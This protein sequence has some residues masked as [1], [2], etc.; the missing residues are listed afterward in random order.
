MPKKKVVES[1]ETAVRDEV[2]KAAVSAALAGR[3]PADDV[4]DDNSSSAKMLAAEKESGGDR[5]KMRYD[6][7]QR[8][9]ER[10]SAKEAREQELTSW[11]AL[12][13]AMQKKSFVRVPISSIR[14]MEE[15]EMVVATGMVNDFRITIPF[16]E[17][18]AS[19]VTMDEPDVR[20]R[21]SRQQRLLQKM[22]GCEV[23]IIITHMVRTPDGDY[24]IAASRREALLLLRRIN[25]EGASPKIVDGD[26][27]KADI[28]SV[29][30]H[31]VRVCAAGYDV[32]V[33]TRALSCR[34]ITDA[35][36]YYCAGEKIDVVVRDIEYDANGHLKGLRA[37]AMEAE[38][39]GYRA[40]LRNVTAGDVCTAQVTRIKA[41]PKDRPDLVRP[42]VF[43]DC[44]NLP[45]VALSVRTDTMATALRSGDRVLFCV[46]GI[47]ERGFVVGDIIRRV[48]MHD[49]KQG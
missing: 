3:K 30:E 47:N 31:S 40:N 43:L 6:A 23:P 22:L 13:N 9:R 24:G 4:A 45:G 14:V 16:V 26:T 5:A 10:E 18:F 25:F 38:L 20:R 44:F 7:R 48:R 33:P 34:Y 21:L 28:I 36:R 19:P 12:K 37:S 35:S 39:A 42:Q 8:E 29:A 32:T 17:M 46:T 11:A 2:E 41:P 27:V 49:G 15:E 1:V